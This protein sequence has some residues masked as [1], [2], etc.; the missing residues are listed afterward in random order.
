MY[1]T[2]PVTMLF[3]SNIPKALHAFHTRATAKE[4]MPSQ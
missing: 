1:E 4:A 2:V 3:G